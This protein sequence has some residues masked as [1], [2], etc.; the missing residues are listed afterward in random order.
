MQPGQTGLR[1]GEFFRQAIED[2]LDGGE[3]IE[4]V[5][6]QIEAS[7]GAGVFE[8]RAQAAQV[9]MHALEALAQF[10]FFGQFAQDVAAKGDFGRICGRFGEEAQEKRGRCQD[11]V[12]LADGDGEVFR[13]DL[14]EKEVGGEACRVPGGRRREGPIEDFGEH[15]ARRAA[16]KG[17][18]DGE[19]R[20]LDVDANRRLGLKNVGDR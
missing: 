11:G 9:A 6:I 1:R 3:R 14:L 13:D 17:E 7:C 2:A 12:T 8:L 10:G 4:L 15:A 20:G 18:G 19:F 5:S 16:C